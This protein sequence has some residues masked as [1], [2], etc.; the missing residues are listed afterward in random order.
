VRLGLTTDIDALVVR[1]ADETAAQ[2]STRA[3]NLRVQRVNERD[4]LQ[5]ACLLAASIA[6]AKES[7]PVIAKPGWRFSSP[8]WPRLGA[9]DVTLVLSEERPVA[10]ELKCGSGRD[11]LGPCAWDVLKLAFALQIGAISRGY[12]IAATGA[13]DWSRTF[14]G[15]ELFDSATIDASALHERFRGWWS[16][17]ERLGDPIPKKVPS[18]LKTRA[19]WTT[20][21]AV[22]DVPWQLKVAA[23]EIDAG[24][25]ITWP[26]RP[27]HR[28]RAGRP[29][30]KGR[31]GGELSD[32]AR[33]KPDQNLERFVGEAG[34]LQP[35]TKSEL[36][37]LMSGDDPGVAPEAIGGGV[38]RVDEPQGKGGAGKGARRGGKG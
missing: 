17:W 28:R 37:R 5:P 34:E 6:A 15:T 1:I 16:Q 19:V 3:A 24:E 4:H 38:P 25:P 7:P 21:F 33:P 31:G 9:V 36:R 20:P 27:E 23:V 29:R 10:L 11:A 30:E 13:E 32:Q 12:L 26:P 14:A 22:A 18:Q 8:H 2:I 35:I